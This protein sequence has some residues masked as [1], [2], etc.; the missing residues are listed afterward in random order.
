MDFKLKMY[1]THV[2]N[3]LIP[4][5]NSNST[6]NLMVNLLNDKL[7]NPLLVSYMGPFKTIDRISLLVLEFLIHLKNFGC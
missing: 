3:G 1:C 4:Y 2:T 5:S 6:S 7:V